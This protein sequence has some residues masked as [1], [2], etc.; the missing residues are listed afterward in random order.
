MDASSKLNTK[1]STAR[2]NS[3]QSEKKA[4]T[5]VELTVYRVRTLSFSVRVAVLTINFIILPTK[6]R[7]QVAV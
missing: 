2:M 7:L 3:K 5:C 1:S 6:K 4:K